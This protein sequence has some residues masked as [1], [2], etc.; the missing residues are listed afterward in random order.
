LVKNKKSLALAQK[1]MKIIITGAARGIGYDTALELVTGHGHEVLALSRDGARLQR[2]ADQTRIQPSRGRLLTLAFDLTHPDFAAL[3]T[4]IGEL[5][6]VE[7]VINNAGLLINK[8]FAVL[9]PGDWQRSFA[10][11]FFAPVELIRF[12]L[13]WMRRSGKAHIVNISSMG[14]FQGS[15]K[16]PGLSAY[17][18]QF[19]QS[20]PR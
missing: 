2:L 6:G 13:P 7:V 9:T 14:G 16:F 5:G 15:A 3:E 1:A 4:A 17:S 18:S 20:R 11:N 8:P 10:T 19:K 12:L